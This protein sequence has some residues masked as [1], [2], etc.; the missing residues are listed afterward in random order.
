MS[1]AEGAGAA[2]VCAA[3]RRLAAKVPWRAS[4]GSSGG[5]RK[6]KPFAAHPINSM[7]KPSD[8]HA[9]LA[10]CACLLLCGAFASADSSAAPQAK[11]AALASAASDEPQPAVPKG[12]KLTY[13]RV[14]QSSTPE[15]IEIIVYEDSDAATYEIRQLD[16]QHGAN[17]FQISA[18]LR[19]KMF[20]LAAQLR[21][22]RGQ[23]L[24]VHRKI[25]NLGE[26]TFRWEQGSEA[27]ETKF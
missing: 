2:P 24:D 1:F 22:F 15:F 20:D 17:P 26:K 12:A 11:P 4:G 16:E 25:A 3:R 5:E 19:A 23:D 7:R 10:L 13:R 21:H 8:R 14:F 18:S 27:H 6:P 9:F